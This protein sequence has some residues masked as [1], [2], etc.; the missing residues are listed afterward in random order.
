M[1]DF[2]SKVKFVLP[3]KIYSKYLGIT[4]QDCEFEAFGN[5]YTGCQYNNFKD[6]NGYEWLQ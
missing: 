1:V 5:K 2:G 3:D 4:Y 6:S